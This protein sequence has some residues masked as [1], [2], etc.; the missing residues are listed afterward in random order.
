MACR[1]PGNKPVSEPMIVSLLTHIY[2]IR[3]QW[4]NKMGPKDFYT[5][6]LFDSF[7]WSDN[8]EQHIKF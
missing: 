7:F 6:L 8:E 3:P 1:R 5:D 4:V 2:V